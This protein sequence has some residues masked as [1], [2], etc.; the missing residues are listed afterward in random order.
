VYYGESLNAL[1][2]V[3]PRLTLAVISAPR[4]TRM[5]HLVRIGDLFLNAG[6]G[7]A[8]IEAFGACVAAIHDGVAPIQL[9]AVIKFCQTI[10]GLA[11]TGIFDPAIG[12][13]QHSGP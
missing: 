9:E 12:L 13:H 4:A 10:R 2:R 6:N 11:I 7:F 3:E 5:R 1:F 8:W